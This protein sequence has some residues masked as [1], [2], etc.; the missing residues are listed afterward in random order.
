MRGQEWFNR[1]GSAES[2]SRRALWK[3]LPETP[4]RDWPIYLFGCILGI[5]VARQFKSN[6]L[7]SFLEK[8]K[9]GGQ[10][11]HVFPRLV[12]WPASRS[13]E[14][15]SPFPLR[16]SLSS[17]FLRSL[18]F[19]EFRFFYLGSIPSHPRARIARFLLQLREKIPARDTKKGLLSPYNFFKIILDALH[20]LLIKWRIIKFNL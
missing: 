16:F 14:I 5:P 7:E 1:D 10:P 2:K 3:D 6:F 9:K 20:L 4:G 12:S 18:F 11:N 8:K 13:A 19:Y 17:T 15:Y